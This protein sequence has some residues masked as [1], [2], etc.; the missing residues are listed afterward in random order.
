MV[1]MRVRVS[2][3]IRQRFRKKQTRKRMCEMEIRQLQATE[4]EQHFQLSEYAF[5]YQLTAE[6]RVLGAKRVAPEDIWGVFIAGKLASKMVI[7]P[8]ETYIHGQAFAMGGIASVATWPEYRRQG[9]VAKLLTYG[10]QVMKEKGQSVSFLHP[11]SYPFYRKYGWEMH[12][13]Y[14]EWKVPVGELPKLKGQGRMVRSVPQDD[15][16]QV[17]Y[18]QFAQRFNGLLKRNSAWWENRIFAGPDKLDVVIYHNKQNEASGYLLYRVRDNKFT[19]KE[20]VYLDQ[21]SYR[22]LWEFIAQHDSMIEQVELRTH[23]QDPLPILSANP[24]FEQRIVPNCMTRIVDVQAFL[25]QYPLQWQKVGGTKQTFVHVTDSWAPWN[26]GTFQIQPQESI[27]SE[28][29]GL[30]QTQSNALR[31]RVTFF[32]RKKVEL[33]CSSPPKKGISCDIQTLSTLMLGYQR[34][35]RLLEI[36]KLTGE[37]SE[38]ELWEKLLA[39]AQTYL[40]D[41]F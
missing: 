12:G 15:T 25:E 21:D 36:E 37:R 26:E 5:Q 34:P 3:L 35:S 19:V 22:G 41:F 18:H 16:L 40:M 20:M 13:E 6:Q 30:L 23:Q 2:W 32:P 29:E 11:F 31:N 1:E 4:L 10:L 9:L 27:Q 7:L 38:I 39:P 8:L 17:L 33:S 28:Q 24:R 14:L